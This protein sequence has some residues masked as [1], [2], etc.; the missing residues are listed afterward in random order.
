[1]LWIFL[2]AIVWLIILLNDGGVSLGFCIIN[3]LI[4]LIIFILLFELRQDLFTNHITS[5][6]NY[7]SL[8]K[9]WWFDSLRGLL[10]H[11]LFL[12]GWK[13]F[14]SG[15]KHFMLRL[16][17]TRLTQC[18]TCPHTFVPLSSWVDLRVSIGLFSD[19]LLE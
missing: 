19:I 13:S 18:R 1:M 12:L 7:G 11:F 14:G 2:I 3:I 10:G 8:H 6:S 5:V 15:I 16:L 17:R 4:F 9:N